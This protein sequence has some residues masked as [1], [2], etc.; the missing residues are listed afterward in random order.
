MMKLPILNNL[1]QKK[2]G[3]KKKWKKSCFFLSKKEK[4]S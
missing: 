1:L 2:M 4:V 3:K